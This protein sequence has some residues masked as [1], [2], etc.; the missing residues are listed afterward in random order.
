MKGLTDIPGIRVGHVSDFQAITGC[1]AI[2][3]EAGGVGGVDIRGSATGTQEVDA[4]AP[5][6]VTDRMHGIL[7]AG[8][9][10]F[11]LEA[12]AGVRRYLS[13]KK[14]GFAFGGQYI[15][16]VP[17][18]ILFDLGI[19]KST[20]H[21]SAA[22][23][24]AAAAA[25]TPEAVSEGCVGA[26]TG[27]TVGKLFGMTRAMK[28]GIGTYTVTLPGGVLV[29]ALVAVNAL[30]DVRDPSNLKIVA[31]ARKSAG[32]AEFADS[33][34]AMLAGT[35]IGQATGNTTLSVVATN[36]RLNKVLANKLAQ[37][38]SLGMARTIYPINTMSDGD[39]SFAISLGD[40]QADVNNLGVAAAEAVAQS[41]LRAVRLAKTM[42]GIIGLAG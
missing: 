19:G 15:P 5:G 36:A 21:P 3:C 28:S 13:A 17:A 24:E 39:V 2:L 33:Q 35:V 9:S 30:G 25:A 29:S 42:G 27:A 37:F 11:G 6:H 41:I 32:S 40:L 26:G 10:A 22:M 34:A 8:G 20:L 38:A 31:G 1:T 16:I 7:L 18:A 23:G 14:V 4:L 12:A